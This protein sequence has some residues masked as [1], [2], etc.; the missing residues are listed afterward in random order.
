MATYPALGG[1]DE[2]NL[3]TDAFSKMIQLILGFIALGTLFI[4]R[5]LEEP[6][7]SLETWFLDVSKQGFGAL[8]IHV[9]NIILSQTMA[10]YVS[11]DVDECGLYFFAFLFD[12]TLGTL[13]L[14]YL[15]K[16]VE[17][18]AVN[19]GWTS[20]EESGHYGN[21]P[22][23]RVWSMQLLAWLGMIIVM[24]LLMLLPTALAIKPLAMFATW[25]FSIFSGH[26]HFELVFVMIIGPGIIN[27]VQFWIT[28]SFLKKDTEFISIESK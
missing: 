12:A 22:D 20:L 3:I 21:P 1:P 18:L 10:D 11:K 4:K 23:Y 8:L 28:D 9:L 16:K 14:L 25:I 5:E 17:H 6:R 19:K 7:R 27:S 26:R 2:C 13:V 24:K 15:L